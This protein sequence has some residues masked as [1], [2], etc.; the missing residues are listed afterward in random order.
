M[1]SVSYVPNGRVWKPEGWAGQLFDKASFFFP[2]QLG[3]LF[4]LKLLH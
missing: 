3:T 2:A 1:E 4:V